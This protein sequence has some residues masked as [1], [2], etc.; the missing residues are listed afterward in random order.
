ML[1][2]GYNY[3]YINEY[4]NRGAYTA[5]LAASLKVRQYR[6][7]SSLLRRFQQPI[8]FCCSGLREDSASLFPEKN[9]DKE[10]RK[11]SQILHKV[12]IDGTFPRRNR[13][14]SVEYGIED[15]IESL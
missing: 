8:R 10:I 13:L 7:L 4:K 3:I 9:S 12:L 14:F 5:I 1:H 15:S 2:K 11:A 6:L